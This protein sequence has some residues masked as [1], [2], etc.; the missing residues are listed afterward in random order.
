MI[1]PQ[2][3]GLSIGEDSYRVFRVNPKS[4]TIDGLV[5]ESS[6]T[7]MLQRI[8]NADV[9]PATRL[10]AISHLQQFEQVQASVR[11][12]VANPRIAAELPASTAETS[13]VGRASQ[14]LVKA[15][16]VLP[17]ASVEAVAAESSPL[18]KA[19][20]VAG[21]RLAIG[22][23]LIDLGIRGHQAY[24]VEQQFQRG[25]LSDRDRV[26]SHAKNGAGMAGGWGGAIA[27]GAQGAA[28]GSTLGPVGTAVGGV[29]GGIGGYL[30]GEKLA[31]G[32][33]EMG[34]EF[35]YSGVNAGRSAT[36][37][38][39]R[40]LESAA[41]AARSGAKHASYQIGSLWNSAR[42]HLGW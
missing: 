18:A 11:S 3:H 36:H 33:V 31:E 13:S 9:S 30:G 20:P 23:A 19:L 42:D 16:E 34:S 35:V 25:R 29:G 37:W 15:A 6:V 38:A 28:W 32:A 8:S 14:Q 7:S 4:G 21:K 10:A 2:L 41:S 26:I 12:R 22:G 17:H 27:L 24:T 39:G 5:S 1:R 40:Q